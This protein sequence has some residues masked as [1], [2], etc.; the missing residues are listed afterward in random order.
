MRSLVRQVIALIK[1]R[2]IFASIAIK[3]AGRKILKKMDKALWTFKDFRPEEFASPDKPDSGYCMDYMFLSKLQTLR[4]YVKRPFI[5]L[6]GYR[7]KAHNIHLRSRGYKASPDSAHLKGLA[8]D[9]KILDSRFLYD[10]FAACIQHGIKRIGIKWDGQ[11]GFLHLDQDE[12]KPA[13]NVIWGY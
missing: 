2:G 8:A 1:G 5:I 9:I 7:T 11:N 4:D 10:L 3:F 6:S 13:Q 12:S